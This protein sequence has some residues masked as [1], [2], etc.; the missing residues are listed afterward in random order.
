MIEEVSM[1]MVVSSM[2]FGRTARLTKVC[3][4]SEH[5]AGTVEWETYPAWL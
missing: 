2:V 1:S 4:R 3:N 5:S